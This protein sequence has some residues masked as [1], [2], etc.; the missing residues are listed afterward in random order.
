MATSSSITKKPKA[1][2]A[3]MQRVAT[4]EHTHTHEEEI[5]KL[6]GGQADGGAGGRQA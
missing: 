4:S 2:Q 5:R 1:K 6:V 3:D